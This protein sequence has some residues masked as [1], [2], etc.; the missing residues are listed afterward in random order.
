[1]FISKRNIL[2][3]V[4][5]GIFFSSNLLYSAAPPQ[6]GTVHKELEKKVAETMEKK[7]AALIEVQTKPEMVIKEGGEKIMV[8]DIVVTGNTV[9]SDQVLAKMVAPYENNKWTLSELKKVADAITGL[10]RKDGYFLAHAFL[11]VQEIKNGVVEITV[12]EGV[13]GEV[14]INGNKHYRTSF[15]N[16]Y[17]AAV[18]KEGAI[19]YSTLERA[20]LLLNDN[21]KLSSDV[22]L[23]AGK[24][25]GA[26]DLYLNVKDKRPVKGYLDYNNFGS[27]YAGPE[28]V[29]LNLDIGDLTGHGDTFSLRGIGGFTDNLYYGKA[30]YTLPLNY[31]GT[32]LGVSYSKSGY[33]VGKEFETLDMRGEGDIYNVVLTH[34]WLRSSTKNLN[35][36]ISFDYKDIH[37]FVFSD[38][39]TNNDILS[40][41]NL[42]LNFDKIDGFFTGGKNY[43]SLYVNQ[44]FPDCMDSLGEDDPLASRPQAET[45]GEFTKLKLDLSRIQKLRSWGYLVL[46]GSGQ[47]TD[48][49]LVPAEQFSVGG[50]D[51]V[52]GYPVT[53]YLGDSGYTASAEL[54]LPLFKSRIQERMQLGFFVDHGENF[55]NTE[56]PGEIEEE[57]TGVG[58]GLRLSLPAETFLRVECAWPINGPDPST[59]DTV[60]WYIQAV[61]FF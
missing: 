44:G 15:I 25:K 36:E 33:E 22:T 24:E 14:S 56:L 32:K 31:Y 61:K 21:T 39:E 38:V 17:F 37:N 18:R 43:L 40:I 30:G 58:T 55:L 9:F 27:R 57:I 2:I 19:K 16:R 48:D 52:R 8:R 23:K 7:K 29:G 1:M 54:R 28:R 59:G 47:L 34:P 3:V 60:T 41:L 49:D 46:R 5:S 10:Y 20:L 6:P 12:L 51:N 42:G 50:V 4:F 13:C 35:F 53:E 45:G 26:T 11:P